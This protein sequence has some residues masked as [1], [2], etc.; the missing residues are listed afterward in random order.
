MKKIFC[1]NFST[2]PGNLECAESLPDFV[3][4]NKISYF[5]LRYIQDM[6]TCLPKALDANVENTE[7][8]I[9][10]LQSR[11]LESKPIPS[12]IPSRGLHMTTFSHCNLLPEDNLSIYTLVS[13]QMKDEGESRQKLQEA[14]L[15]GARKL[16]V[17]K[18]K[19][20]S[21]VEFAAPQQ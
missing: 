16:K 12:I 6:G 14:L 18:W 17:H 4:F 7:L 11:Q 8:V 10:N 3:F 19:H 20:L 5:I 1:P 15:N 2:F 9:Q 13:R 21:R